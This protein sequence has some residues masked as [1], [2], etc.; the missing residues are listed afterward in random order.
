[1]PLSYKFI[2]ALLAFTGCISLLITGELIP[3]FMVPGIALIPGYYRF[4]RG[5]EPAP[6]WVISGLA[7]VAAGVV[8]FDTIMVSGDFFVAVAHM[9][10]VFQVLKSFDLRVPWDH[11]QVYFMSLLQMIM[12]SEMAISMAVGGI[13]VVFLFIFVAAIVLSHFMK[14]GALGRVSIKKPVAIIS[15]LAF[16]ATAALFVT[17]PRAKGS[18][19][20]RKA[21]HGLRSVGFSEKVD[22]G[23]FGDVLEDS[24]IVMRVS[25][26]GPKLP[27][28]WRGITLD[29]FDGTAWK[30]TLKRRARID[31]FKGRF[32]IPR[33]GPNGPETVQK[34]YLEPVD[35]DVIFGLGGIT[36]LESRGWFLY[37]DIA[38]SLYL[39]IKS[40]RKFSYT[41]HSVPRGDLQ[42][43]IRYMYYYLQMPPGVE[44]IRALAQE[45]AGATETELETAWLIE[46]YLR[47][48]YSYALRTSPP[49]EG[50]SPIEDF[51]FNTRGGYCEHFA[52]S[53]VLML[54]SVG[55]QSRIVT[56]FAG[57]KEN[58][59]GDYI[60]VRQKD[61][62]SWVEAGIDG[63]WIRFDPT[64]P[65][66][67]G[68]LF[69]LG[70]VIDS[71][72]M[73]W[74]RYVVGF[75]SDDRRYL[76]RSMTLPVIT[77]PEF[78]GIRLNIRP[79]YLIVMAVILIPLA[80]GFM[81]R[82]WPQRKPFETKA[83]LKF[84]KAV[85]KRGGN[86]RASSTPAEVV[87]EARRL[88]M[89]ADGAAEFVRLYE[90][91]RF[92]GIEF[93]REGRKKYLELAQLASSRK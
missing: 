58:A 38:G 43:K 87:R 55:I 56:G 84:R 77:M 91:A 85:K 28:Y 30:D 3:L 22:F 68:E 75:D 13:F 25:V 29:Y 34:I 90:V 86:V 44:R 49:P 8:A 71:L 6:R 33:G 19:W 57:G 1:M 26:S 53:M 4:L 16:V 2:T 40:D 10:I 47:T 62:H 72:K 11:L 41:A 5:G 18:I 74:Y 73:N 17:V 42:V 59:L 69:V 12:A 79:V 39:P 50:V 27:L 65:A 32:S 31:K 93:N 15:L 63:K 66:P 7:A 81:F 37:R 46:N 92:G 83:Y 14:E 9:T 61:A 24:S 82:R 89:D 23:S 45:V 20:Q 21:A 52:T 78:A 51:L 60:I 54:R 67:E 36:S 48:N 35:N 76:F 80:S 70:R 88:N 64:P